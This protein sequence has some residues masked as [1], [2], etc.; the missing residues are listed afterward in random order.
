MQLFLGGSH[1]ALTQV[2][3]TGINHAVQQ[4]RLPPVV[5]SAQTL[6]QR[7]RV[8]NLHRTDEGTGN[9]EDAVHEGVGDA[10]GCGS[11]VRG[12]ALGVLAN[13]L[14]RLLVVGRRLEFHGPSVVVVKYYV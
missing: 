1:I 12:G 4:V 14:Q 9:T 6:A 13:R 8:G 2:T 10:V 11:S 7:A 3:L 5:P